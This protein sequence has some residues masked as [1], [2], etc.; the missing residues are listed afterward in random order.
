MLL[1]I[2]IAVL[3]DYL[4]KP[5]SPDGRPV[6]DP[7]LPPLKEEGGHGLLGSKGHPAIATEEVAEEQYLHLVTPLT[8]NC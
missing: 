1:Q 5:V 7:V 3:K 6:V 8:D 4:P 2:K